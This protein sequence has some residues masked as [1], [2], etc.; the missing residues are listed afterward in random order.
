MPSQCPCASSGIRQEQES[1]AATPRAL[2]VVVISPLEISPPRSRHSGTK[3]HT[4]TCAASEE[5]SQTPQSP[6]CFVGTGRSGRGPGQ[7][8]FREVAASA[9]LAWPAVRLPHAGYAS[10]HQSRCA[11]IA[12][13]PAS[14]TRRFRPARIVCDL[15]HTICRRSPL[16][17]RWRANWVG[18]LGCCVGVP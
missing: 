13:A 6:R 7:R 12:I 16:Q 14:L 5:W 11:G 4:Q 15:G 2:W 1:P 9:V 8:S 10:R 3:M 18:A 17:I